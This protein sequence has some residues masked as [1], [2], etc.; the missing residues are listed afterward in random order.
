[1]LNEQAPDVPSRVEAELSQISYEVPVEQPKDKNAALQTLTHL[2]G[3]QAA[4]GQRL[5]PKQI[6]CGW[7]SC[8]WPGSA[9]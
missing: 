9:C 5:R 3:K 2:P 6:S 7:F 8:R 1:M 4:M